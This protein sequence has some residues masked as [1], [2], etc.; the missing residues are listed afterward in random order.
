MQISMHDVAPQLNHAPTT[1]PF[2]DNKAG[3]CQESMQTSSTPSPPNIMMENSWREHH[4][5]AAHPAFIRERTPPPG[6]FHSVLSGRQPVMQLHV[7]YPV[8]EIANAVV[9]KRTAQLRLEERDLPM[10]SRERTAG[11]PFYNLMKLVPAKE[12]RLACNFCRVRKIKCERAGV[13][14]RIQGTTD[15]CCKL[16]DSSLMDHPSCCEW[17]AD[18]ICISSVS[19]HNRPCAR[20]S[21]PCI[22]PS[23]VRRVVSRKPSQPSLDDNE[24]VCNSATTSTST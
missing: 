1:C 18:T 17:V 5:H 15:D 7:P 22:Y 21:I 11:Y 24:T 13:A 19:L 16:S 10:R 14:D 9:P 2:P 3:I 8:T 23:P 6:F 20:R 4:P 12:R